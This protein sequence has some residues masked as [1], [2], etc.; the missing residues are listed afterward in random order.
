MHFYE[1]GALRRVHLRGVHA[2]IL[3]RVLVHTGG[4]NLCLLM[5]RLIGVGTPRGLQERFAAVV[6]ALAWRLR[7][8]PT[9]IWTP[10]PRYSSLDDEPTTHPEYAVIDVQMRAFTTGC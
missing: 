1:T 10:D 5:R 9:R 3:K 6:G 4:F 2:N 7:T 8:A